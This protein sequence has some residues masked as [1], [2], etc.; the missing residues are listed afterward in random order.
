MKPL[1]VALF[2]DSFHEVNGAAYTFRQ[3]QAFAEGRGLPLLVVHSGA[4]ARCFQRGSVTTMEL[5]RSAA[6]FAVDV[7]FGFDSLLWRYWRRIGEALAAFRADVVHIISPGDFSVLGACWAHKLRIPIVASFHT[8]LHQFASARLQK[9][10]RRVPARPRQAICR[11]VE[12]ACGRGLLKYYE[13]PRLILAPN[14][15]VKQWLERATGRACRIMRRGWISTSS[16]RRVATP[17]MAFFVWATWEGSRGRR[18][19]ASSWNSSEGSSP[20]ARRDIDS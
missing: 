7:D 2:T 18:T 16:I 14:P 13:I 17:T 12:R 20:P 4:E 3:Y 15:E 10:L 9:T 5:K 6:T 11:T 19:S 8:N 1:R